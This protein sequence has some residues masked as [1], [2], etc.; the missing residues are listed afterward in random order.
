MARIVAIGKIDGDGN[1]LRA[2]PGISIGPG[3]QVPS[4]PENGSYRVIFP[5]GLVR[6]G[7]YIIQLTVEE[8]QANNDFGPTTIGLVDQGIQGFE[9]QIWGIADTPPYNLLVAKPSTWH[10]V[11]YELKSK[12]LKA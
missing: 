9:V 12:G 2:T 4:G 11:V 7:N 8:T 10:F 5:E 6:D 1:I 3:V